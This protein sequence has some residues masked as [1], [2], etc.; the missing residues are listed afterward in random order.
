MYFLIGIWGG[1]R[2]IYAAVKFFIFTMIGSLFMLVAIIALMFLTRDQLGYFSSSIIDFYKLN[3]PFVSGMLLNPQNLMFLAFS[4]AFAIKVPI[5][6]FHTWLPDAHVEAPTSGSVILAGIMLKLGAY[7]FLRW[8][9]PLFYDSL[10]SFYLMFL[11]LAVVGIVYGALMAFVQTD[12]KKLVAYSSVSHMGYVILG[13]FSLNIYGVTG[14]LYQMLNHGISTSA[15]FLLVGMIYTR[16]KTR[17]MEEYGGLATK[18][19][20]FAILF[21]IV[22][23]ASIAVPG[24]NGFIGEL[25]ILLGGFQVNKILAGIAVLGVVLGAVYMLY[26]YKKVFYGKQSK[27]VESVSSDLKLNEIL[28]LIPF[29]ILIFVMGIIPNK[30]LDFSKASINHLVENQ[31]TYSLQI[32]GLDIQEIEQDEKENLVDENIEVD[33]DPHLEPETTGVEDISEKT[34]DQ[35]VQN[36]DKLN[37]PTEVAE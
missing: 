8:A 13:L 26:M 4:L 7:G 24:T 19:P 17:D 5:V 25:L 22:T 1:P 29:A 9:M 36:I 32:Y 12:I 18:M 35:Q 27:V 14:G 31:K 16:T 20:V 11:I 34:E 23:M 30:F 28:V 37:I 6:P 33:K 21:F 15:L 10:E 3:I 2:K